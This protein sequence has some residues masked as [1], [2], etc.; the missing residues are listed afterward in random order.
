VTDDM[1]AAKPVIGLVGGIG[2]GKSRVAAALARRGGRVVAGD[3]LGH[4][5]LKQ[6]AIRD[7]VISRWGTGILGADGQ[8]DRRKLGAVV[9]ADAAERRALEAIVQPWIGERLR[10]QIA[11]AQSDAA[12]AFIVLDAAVMLEAGW[13]DAVDLLVYVHA[14]Q[15]VRLGRVAEQRGWS[16]DEVAARQDAQLSLT[17][18]AARADVAVDNSGSLAELEPQLDRLLARLGIG[19]A[20]RPVDDRRYDE[21]RA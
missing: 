8:I 18:K 3:P 13:E 11:A 7:L 10:E 17:E 21:I 5:A 14:P 9:F 2:S 16:P 6:P 20:A 1:S 19:S 12:V 15:A 4:E